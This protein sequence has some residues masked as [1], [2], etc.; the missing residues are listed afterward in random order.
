NQPVQKVRVKRTT[1]AKTKVKDETV[2][3]Q[4]G[5]DLVVTTKTKAKAKTKTKVATVMAEDSPS[6][7]EIPTKPKAKPKTKTKTKTKAPP[8]PS[9]EGDGGVAT[10]TA[11][12]TLKPAKTARTSSIPPDVLE[13]KCEQV[14]RFWTVGK[15]LKAAA[16]HLLQ[17]LDAFYNDALLEHLVVHRALKTL[18]LA[19]QF[20]LRPVLEQGLR[21]I[22]LRCLEW[23]VTNYAKK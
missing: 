16:R 13:H 15:P 5:D 7:Q 1:K 10:T 20:E 14:G 23:L 4:D 18:D 17:R 22:S 11:T 8:K 9:T 3:V 2:A 6:E 21:S 19:K 12:T